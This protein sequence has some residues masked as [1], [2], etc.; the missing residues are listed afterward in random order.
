MSKLPILFYSTIACWVFFAGSLYVFP[1]SLYGQACCSGGVPVSGGMGL[2]PADQGVWQLQTTLDHQALGVLMQGGEI[3]D[4]DG[5]T[6]HTQSLLL[7]VGYQWNQR[8]GFSMLGTAIRQSRIIH[9]QPDLPKDL[10]VNMGIGDAVALIRF[11]P[12][13][14]SDKTWAVALGPKVPTGSTNATDPSGILLPPDLQTGTGTWDMIGWTLYQHQWKRN[15]NLTWSTMINHKISG[16]RN[17]YL[18]NQTY[19]FGDETTL[20]STWSFRQ[21]LGAFLIDPLVGIRI[22]RL[23][24]DIQNGQSVD[25]SG[26]MWVFGRIGTALR[27][28]P[29]QYL[30]IQWDLPVYRMVTGVQLGPTSQI[31]LMFYW[32]IPNSDHRSIPKQQPE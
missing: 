21:F 14:T 19:R 20:Q 29:R 18:G 11:F 7:E 8:W 10:T 30:R 5:R 13:K 26:G 2:A 23:G 3:L 32:E 28:T 27:L 1:T 31:N 9:T 6:R 12:V 17:D 25:N 4:R 15:P 16:Q 22:R 24:Q